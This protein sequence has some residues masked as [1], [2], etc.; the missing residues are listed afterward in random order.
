MKLLK[1]FVKFLGQVIITT[2]T[3]F[4]RVCCKTVIGRVTSNV[5][6]NELIYN[7]TPITGLF[8]LGL[9]QNA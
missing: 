7:V 8:V 5:R 2:R 9:V 1:N 4:Q 3:I 6:T